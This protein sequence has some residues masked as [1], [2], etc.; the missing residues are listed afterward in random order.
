MKE[1]LIIVESPSKA[2][3]IKSY[4]G[5][6]YTVLSSVGHVRDLA[7]SGVG[8]FGL[9]IENDFKPT[10]VIIRGKNKVVNEIK[11]AAKGKKV[12]IAT[13]PDREGEAIGWH[14][15]DLLSLKEN[16]DNRII[17][18]EITKQTI[19][20]ALE[21]PR[22]IDINLVNSQ[23]ARRSLDRII[24]F[25]LSNLLQRKIR[26]K[27]AGRVQSVALKMIVDLEKEIQ[28]FVPEV[29][30][31]IQAAFNEF[32]ADYI[33]PSN[34]RIKKEEADKIVKESTNPFI[35][36]EIDIKNQERKPKLPFTTSTLQQDANTYLGMSGSRTMMIAQ[37]LYEG[38]EVNGELTGLITYM[39]TDSTR[40]SNTYVGSALKL[41]E[42]EYGKDYLGKYSFTK[43]EGSQDAHE[44]IRPTSLKN[45][46]EDLINVLDKDQYRLYER[47]YYRTLASLMSNAIFERHKV[48]LDAKGNLYQVNGVRQVFDGFLKVY[49]EQK[50]KDVVLPK[51]NIGDE[52]TANK[53]ESIKKQTQPKARYS[54]A[55][56]I[57]DME[58][59]GIGR[60]ST[61]AQTIQ[62]L[63]SKDRD[64]LTIEK[65]RLI[66]TEQGILTSDVLT[67]YFDEIIN[68]DY[69]KNME[70]NLD[71]IT[72]G[73]A[74][75]PELLND[76]YYKF[77]EKIDYADKNM[78]RLP[79]KLLDEL[80]PVCGKQ[81][82]VRKSKYGEFIGCSGY[83]SCKYI[84][85]NDENAK[86]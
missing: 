13:D 34:T 16:D 32:N 61:Y 29:Y 64:Y 86:K 59:K 25:K 17:F 9:D 6:E 12:L 79:P 51:L 80:C 11:K 24:G 8:G 83:P 44:A 14:L 49:D 33:I 45:R 60:P 78:K 48:V 75:G 21:N 66:P 37:T 81:L 31:E 20:E 77:I 18:T 58:E 85:N 69:T 28:A 54:E 15:A 19:L 10:Y 39:R 46:P 57:K 36:K 84:K 2:R 70:E 43:K 7:I 56:L 74:S 35:V 4:L 38:I 63:K 40:L 55:T 68:V 5:D 72:E 47:I 1:K 50:T 27:S 73:K 65:R 52:L 76:F 82:V 22:P 53:V 30:Y 67:K 3:T 23:E 26:S 71:L 41:I 42:E 62:T